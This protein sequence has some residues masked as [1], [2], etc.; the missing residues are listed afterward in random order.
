MGMLF[1]VESEGDGGGDSGDDRMCERNDVISSVLD[2]DMVPW[3]RMSWA[4]VMMLPVVRMHCVGV[5]AA[6]VKTETVFL[7]DGDGGRSKG[8]G[9]EE[10]EWPPYMSDEPL[11]GGARRVGKGCL[12]VKSSERI[13]M[14][15]NSQSSESESESEAEL[16]SEGGGKSDLG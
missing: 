1:G 9:D 7:S 16:G 14:R 6:I 4:A 3:R 11:P 10:G 12:L 15:R 8:V 5:G 2:L 13:R